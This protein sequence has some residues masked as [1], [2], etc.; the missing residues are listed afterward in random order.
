MTE[1]TAMKHMADI[2]LIEF[3]AGRLDG[4]RGVAVKAHVEQCP[5]CAERVRDYSQTWQMLGAWQLPV[6]RHLRTGEVLQTVPQEP[7]PRIWRLRKQDIYGFLRIAAAIGIVAG[8]GYSAGQ[9]T[10]RPQAPMA[11]AD[12]PGYLSVLA[13]DSAGSL[14]QLILNEDSAPGEEM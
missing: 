3:V 12:A 14:S 2:E 5:Q 8:A 9:W 1:N 7:A 10:A 11:S 6:D 4:D 13:S